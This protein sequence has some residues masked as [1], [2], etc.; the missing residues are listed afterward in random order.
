L[1]QPLLSPPGMRHLT[2]PASLVAFVNLV[3]LVTATGCSGGSGGTPGSSTALSTEELLRLSPQ[4]DHVAFRTSNPVRKDRQ[5]V[6]EVTNPSK[7]Q[8]IYAAT[9]GLPLSPNVPPGAVQSCFAIINSNLYDFEF[10][11]ADG[12]VVA[13]AHIDP[14]GCQGPGGTIGPSEGGARDV[15]ALSDGYWHTI[16]S[17]LEVPFKTVLTLGS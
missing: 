8:S 4:I 2:T 6:I 16:A 9:S 14:N 13:R 1:V 5:I 15:D 12:S 11:A 10:L 17:D 7:A 3:I